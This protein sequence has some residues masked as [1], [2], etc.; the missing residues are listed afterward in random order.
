MRS[1][2]FTVR[3]WIG[4]AGKFN[5]NDCQ[6]APSLNEMKM[7]FLR[8]R[9]EQALPL[10]IFAHRMHVAV[11]RQPAGDLCPALAKSVVLKI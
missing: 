3:S 8:A 1:S 2:F 5:L 7:P 6:C 4:A 11:L 9:K 10:G